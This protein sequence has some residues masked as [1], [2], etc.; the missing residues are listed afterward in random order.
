[1]EDGVVAKLRTPEHAARRRRNRAYARAGG[2]QGENRGYQLSASLA[3]YE[4]AS[5][6]QTESLEML[7]MKEPP[8]MCMKKKAT[9]T[10]CPAKNRLFTR[11]C[12]NWAMIDN[13]QSG[14]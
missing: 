10:K 7:E 14:F 1:V 13:N 9:M 2:A 6:N 5:E 11:K 3:D 12:T 4:P 8:G